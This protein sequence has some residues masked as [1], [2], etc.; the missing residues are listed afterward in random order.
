MAEKPDNRVPVAGKDGKTM[1]RRAKLPHRQRFDE[2]MAKPE[3]FPAILEGVAAN[4]FGLR[5]WAKAYDLE[6]TRVYL[7]LDEDPKRKEAYQ[8][9]I[10]IKAETIVAGIKDHFSNI[11]TDEHGLMTS[12]GVN[13]AKAKADHDRWIAA[14]M[15]PKDY[16]DRIEVEQHTTV[17]I[18]L[19]SL[20]DRR[21]RQLAEMSATIEHEPTKQESRAIQQ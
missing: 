14:K 12:P 1:L 7:W 9:A 13:L 4:K 16:G 6:V 8:R 21:E 15:A 2:L 5:E 19:R 18:D 20:L 17:K 10:A 3:T 11:E